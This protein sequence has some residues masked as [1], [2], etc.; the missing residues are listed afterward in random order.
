[1]KLPFYKYIVNQVFTNKNIQHIREELNKKHYYVLTE[2][3]DEVFKSLLESSSDSIRECLVDRRLLDLE[4]PA[5]VDVLKYYGIYEMYAY[6]FFKDKN[7]DKKPSCVKWF[8]DI[9]WIF[10]YEDVQSIINIFLFNEEDLSV[11]SSIIQFKFRKKLGLRTLELYKDIFWDTTVMSA[12]EALHYCTLLKNSSYIARR[13]S[14][15]EVEVERASNVF[16]ESDNGITKPFYGMDSAYIKWK[17]G[18]TKDLEVPSPKDFLK[19]IQ[20]DAMFKYDEALH[21]ERAIDVNREEGTGFEGADI[22]VTR[23]TRKNV[24]GERLR[25]MKGYVDLFIKATDKMPEDSA[26]EE[27]FFKNLDQLSMNFVQKEKIVSISDMDPSV[28]D[29]VKLDM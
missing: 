12:K 6:E 5:H 8:E 10:K 2:E 18:Y 3:I 28:L 16:P 20:V 14:D 23:T 26:D 13:F 17:L 11:V 25:L 1:M 27:S 24:E 4:N 21:M 29:D 19:R 7:L 15:G 22:N 9:E